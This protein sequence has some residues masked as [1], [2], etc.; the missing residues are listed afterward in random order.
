MKSRSISSTASIDAAGEPVVPADVQRATSDSDET[1]DLE[2][3]AIAK[4]RRESVVVP[5]GTTAAYGWDED[6]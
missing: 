4:E 5:A 3:P 2:Q 1:I 6:E